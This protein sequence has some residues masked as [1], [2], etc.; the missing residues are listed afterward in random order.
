MIKTDRLLKIE[1]V[2]R[3]YQMGQVEVKALTNVSLEIMRGEFIVILGPS[4]SGKTTLLNLIG[5]MDSPTS[6]KLISD[7]IDITALDE[8]G[9]T[10]YRRD[11]IGFVFQFFN[12][13]PSLTARENIEFAAE[14][15]KEPREA[16]ETLEVVGLR[17]RADHY[18][19]E[20][21]GGEQQR[22]AIARAI[23]KDPPL[24]L[25]DE[26]TGDLDFDTG[27]HIL[28]AMRRINQE[29][30]KTVLLVTHNTAI[31]GIADRVVRMRSGEIVELKENSS[32]IDPQ[33]L[34]W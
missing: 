27:K 2:S 15:V 17:D 8:K 28:S 25:C 3:I 20:L 14:L 9:L 4:G 24:L 33:E 19:S 18:P 32:P 30:Q 21:S 29:R 10:R 26:P 12:L 13:I 11:H 7:G 22:V 34:R 31:G 1:D 6:G 23:V 5:G 16:L